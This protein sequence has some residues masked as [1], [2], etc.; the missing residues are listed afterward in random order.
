[1]SDRSWPFDVG[2]ERKPRFRVNGENV[3]KSGHWDW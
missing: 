3:L 1:M 2:C